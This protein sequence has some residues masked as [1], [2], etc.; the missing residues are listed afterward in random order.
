MTMP[1]SHHDLEPIGLLLLHW[2][3]IRKSDD[4]V[5][6]SSAICEASIGQTEDSCSLSVVLGC[7]CRA[8]LADRLNR[9]RRLGFKSDNTVAHRRQT[10]LKGGN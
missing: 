7:R 10:I 5:K 2:N 4:G 1:P 3:K 6:V 8:G 9:R